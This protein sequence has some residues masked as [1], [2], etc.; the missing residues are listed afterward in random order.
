MYYLPDLLTFVLRQ[1]V[2]FKTEIRQQI[3]T[4]MEMKTEIRLKLLKANLVKHSAVL[5]QLG[6][7]CGIKHR[8]CLRCNFADSPYKPG[9]ASQDHRNAHNHQIQ[10]T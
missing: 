3:R 1:A 9:N 8:F 2:S 6:N 7:V 10:P 4:P 5:F